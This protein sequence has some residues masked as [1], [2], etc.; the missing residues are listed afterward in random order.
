MKVRGEKLNVLSS[1]SKEIDGLKIKGGTG[2]K[3]VVGLFW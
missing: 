2:L 1:P 3:I